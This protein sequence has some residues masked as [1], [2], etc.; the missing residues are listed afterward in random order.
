MLLLFEITIKLIIIDRIII[1]QI[2]TIR[3]ILSI[4]FKNFLIQYSNPVNQIINQSFYLA[5]I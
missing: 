4:S 5:N 3:K 2:K 1:K